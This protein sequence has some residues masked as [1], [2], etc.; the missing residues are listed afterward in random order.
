MVLQKHT[1]QMP[2]T[3]QKIHVHLPNQ[4]Q[5]LEAPQAPVTVLQ[6]LNVEKNLGEAVRCDTIDL[7]TGIHSSY[8][9]NSFVFQ[10]HFNFL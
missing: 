8:F 4:L 6:C 9:L 7:A 5:S 10:T 2:T 3:D 1:A